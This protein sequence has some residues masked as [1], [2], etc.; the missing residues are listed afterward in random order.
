MQTTA[1]TKDSADVQSTRDRINTF[2]LN[3][4]LQAQT[5][6]RRN[7]ALTK[8]LKSPPKDR[9][10]LQEELTKLKQDPKN[11]KKVWD[12]TLKDELG[13]RKLAEKG[14]QAALAVLNK[15]DV[16]GG[17][18]EKLR[19]FRARVN[20]HLMC[21]TYLRWRAVH[22][23]ADARAQADAADARMRRELGQG[24]DD[25]SSDEEEEEEDDKAKGKDA[26]DGGSG[27]DAHAG[28]T[29]AQRFSREAESFLVV[30]E[31]DVRRAQVLDEILALLDPDTGVLLPDDYVGVL[32]R[33]KWLGFAAEAE[34][35]LR[36]AKASGRVAEDKA[37]G[38][39]QYGLT[40]TETLLR[41]QMRCM[42][43]YLG[44]H[45]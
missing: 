1:I 33:M 42:G 28:E 16:D 43:P 29:Q 27:V 30:P 9:D 18:P 38:Q 23:Q 11:A 6:T 20:Y 13:I 26:Q 32:E 19:A 35:L 37:L 10:K 31:E 14:S 17:F 40:Q 3:L 45:H 7:E 12:D 4:D 8:L 15:V 5:L 21:L 25:T 22:E 34:E 36:Q 44:R 2:T 24:D 39:D 41:F